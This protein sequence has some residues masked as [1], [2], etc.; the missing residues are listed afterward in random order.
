MATDPPPFVLTLPSDLCHLAVARAFIEAVCFVSGLD[1]RATDAVALAVHEA[2]ANVIRHAHGHRAEVP[3]ELR[4]FPGAGGIEIH[5]LDEGEPFDL[6][7]VPPLDPG[8]LRCG[9]RGLFL[10][11]ALTD[12]LSCQPRGSRGNVLRLVKRGCGNSADRGVV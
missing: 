6:A 8:E 10:M 5:I 9:G 2:L 7:K 4:C 1:R 12:E 3:L 11:R